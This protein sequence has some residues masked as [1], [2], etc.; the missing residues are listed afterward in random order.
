MQEWQYPRNQL[1]Y[2]SELGEGQFGKVLLMKAQVQYPSNTLGSCGVERF[3]M[4]YQRGIAGVGEDLPV[5]VKTL[6]SRDPE[7]VAKFMEEAELMKRFSHPN[8]VSLLGRY[9]KTYQ[10]QCCDHLLLQVLVQTMFWMMTM[11]H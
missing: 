10:C 2:M 7:K 8:I 9:S 3:C 1:I 11:L 5:A 6:A 4:L